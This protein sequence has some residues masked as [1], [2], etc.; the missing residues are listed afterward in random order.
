MLQSM[1]ENIRGPVAYILVGLIVVVF[2]F[3]MGDFFTGGL[4]Q[5]DIIAEVNGRQVS[6]LEVRRAVEM[7]KQQLRSM[8]GE[9]VDP[10]FLSDEFLL[11]SIRESVIEREVLA[12][13]AE[14][15]GL[16]V[17]T[18][19]LDKA[20]RE[21][22]TFHRDGKFDADHYKSL[23]RQYAYTPASY[24]DELRNGQILNQYQQT[25]SQT[26]FVTDQ[27]TAEL[28]RLQFETRSFTFVT[29][30]LE[31]TLPNIVTTE[32][33]V[34]AFYQQHKQDFMSQA[35][36]ATEYLLINKQTLASSV[37]VS[38][39][40]IQAQYDAEVAEAKDKTER[41]AAHILI[42][43]KADG[44]HTALLTDLQQKIAAG[45]SFAELAK[46]HSADSG[47]ATQGGDVGV[48]TGG[49]FVPEFEDALKSLTVGQVSQPVKT[50]FGY[51]IIKLLD[52]KAAV[53]PT[54]EQSR[55]RI[56]QALK[57]DMTTDLYS[58]K[59][60]DLRESSAGASSLQVVADKLSSG[61]M[62]LKVQQTSLFSKQ[63]PI[64]LFSSNL[65]LRN[66]KVLDA[67]FAE[68]IRTG[69]VTELL[70]LDANN[71]LVMRITEFQ[72]A[73]VQALETVKP[74]VAE[75]LQRERA[76]EQLNLRANEML[77]R[78]LSS[79]T[80]E[81]VAAAERLPVQQFQDKGR[82]EASVNA[83]IL[84]KVFTMPKPAAGAMTADTLSL[85]N[86][87]WAVIQVRDSKSPAVELLT[88]EQRAEVGDQLQGSARN[89]EFSALLAMLTEQAD[90]VRRKQEAP[91]P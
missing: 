42:E 24:R 36:A 71:A 31:K 4:R 84:K 15:S 19:D 76:G 58:E 22:T 37:K 81:S 29:L 62:S 78:L 3:S 41:H 91:A 10:R 40:D 61:S 27:E 12:S 43:E 9:N 46:A 56:E 52:Q 20:I 45:E 85:S 72:P 26:A 87:D 28:A 25:F 89:G 79:E 38:E 77:Q 54:L 47:S 51:H 63:N 67:V 60:E 66:P 34:T 32:E 30:P 70:E 55:L 33:E 57:T 48:T 44:S 75:R 59:L 21:D 8:L 11:P 69:S 73:A 86:G 50:Q 6:D 88:A 53:V 5:P 1:R 64:A 14:T 90:I 17:S 49:S 74:A 18:S 65:M 23:L 2:G 82:K 68:G 39:E 16:R 80:L 83:E 13:A 7:R 35:Q